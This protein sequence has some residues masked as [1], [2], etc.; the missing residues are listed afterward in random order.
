MFVERTAEQ[1]RII[2]LAKD[3]AQEFAPRAEQHDREGGKIS[4]SRFADEQENL[5]ENS[6]SS[7]LSSII[8]CWRFYPPQGGLL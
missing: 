3:L 2:A 8:K 4:F 1:Q 5:I 6:S 7:V